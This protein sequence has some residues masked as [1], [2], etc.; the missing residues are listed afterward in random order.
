MCKSSTK[1]NTISTQGLA[2]I[3]SSRNIVGFAKPLHS[4]IMYCLQKKYEMLRE[5]I[6]LNND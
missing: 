5:T 2:V 4:F 1:L 3:E 6:A